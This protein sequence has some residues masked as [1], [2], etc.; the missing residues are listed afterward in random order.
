MTNTG[1]LSNDA[2]T[3]PFT[4]EEGITYPGSLLK[5]GTGAG[6]VLLCD[7]GEEP[8]GWAYTSTKHPITGVAQ[9]NV[10][11]GV[12]AFIPG[13]EVEV[14]LLATN[15][16]IVY[17]DAL[18][19]TIDGTVDKKSGAGWIVGKAMEAVASNA[20]AGKFIKVRIEKEYAAS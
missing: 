19:T 15:D 13:Y 11:V 18:E 10:T 7:A 20:G 14:P 12:G 2:P 17:G 5:L 1:G 6:K 3:Q 16:T 8:I 9:S 4:A